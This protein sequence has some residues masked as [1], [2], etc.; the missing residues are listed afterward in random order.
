MYQ[1]SQIKSDANTYTRNTMMLTNATWPILFHLG[2][3]I[4]FSGSLGLSQSITSVLSGPEPSLSVSTG[5]TASRST[6]VSWEA[7]VLDTAA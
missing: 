3:F 1:I 5:G 2:Q 6:S 7:I 4:G